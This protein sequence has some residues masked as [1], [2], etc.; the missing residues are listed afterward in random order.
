MIK[1][2]NVYTVSKW[3]EINN[4]IF[5]FNEGTKGAQFCQNIMTFDIETTNLWSS[6]DGTAVGFDHILYNNDEEYRNKIDNAKPQSCLYIWQMAIESQDGPKVFIGR[7]WKDYQDFMELLSIEIRRQSLYGF[8]TYNRIS[9]NISSQKIK[10]NVY[11]KMYVHNLGFEFQHIRNIFEDK[12]TH[13]HRRKGSVFARS[14]RKP[15]KCNINVNKVAWEYR[16]TLVLTQKS[17][18]K[19]CEDEKLPVQKLTEPK[20]YYLKMRSPLT[21]LTEEEINYSIND[22]VSMIYGIEKY[23]EKYGTLENIPL[24][25]TGAVRLKCREN[26]CNTNPIWAGQCSEI[27]QSYSP[28]EFK[29]LVQLFQGGW[30][31]G[32]NKYINKVVGTKEHP[33]RCTDFASSYPAVMCTRRYPVSKFIECDVDEFGDL[34]AQNIHTA[35]F[36]WYM[37]VTVKNCK[38]KLDN[39][40]WSLSKVCFEDGKPQLKCPIADNGRLYYFEEA[41]MYMTDLD[42]DTFKLAYNFEEYE[43]KELYKSVA[44]YLPVEIIKTILEYYSYKTTLKVEEGEENPNESL[45]NESKQFINAIYGCAV[46]KIVTDEVYFS[47][48]GWNSQECDD[49]MFFDT[50]QGYTPDKTFLAYQQGIWVTA[51]AR[52]GLWDFISVLDKRVVYCDTDSIKGLFT[53]EDMQFIEEYNKGIEKLENEVAAH[54]G[55]DPELYAPKTKK[56]KS[57]RLGIMARE[58]DCIL[59]CL[60]AK[61]YVAKHGDHYDS[62]IAGLPKSA[63]R[64]KI[65]SFNDFSNHTLF[66]TIESEKLTAVYNDNQQPTTFIDRD[67]NSY[68][69]TD[70]YGICLQPT[71]FDLSISSEFE[72]FLSTVQH[73]FIDRNDEFFANN[74]P[75]LYK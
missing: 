60:G 29:R 47:V 53:D 26:V 27:T 72:K 34:E 74:T 54:L 10:K 15:M 7:T 8:K 64:N 19:W 20:D 4:I 24:T 1:V 16:D 62:T 9:E 56:G 6:D 65:K 68:T 49:K 3:E 33:C 63:G 66:N 58:E 35:E 45:Y 55:I 39:T 52:H 46:T 73:G 37:K 40:Y 59:K 17:L 2:L 38:T 57:K 50:I 61:R 13:S 48:D 32:N 75:Y 41:T 44:D 11:A 23:R 71:T 42:W 22:V 28:E 31:H 69:C 30:T 25:Q 14:P 51:W 21:E 5:R 12:L 18:K 43:V 70:K 67:G 36:R